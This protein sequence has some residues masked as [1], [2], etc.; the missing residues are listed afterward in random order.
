MQLNEQIEK[1]KNKDF[2]KLEKGKTSNLLFNFIKDEIIIRSYQNNFKKSYFD[3]NISN[4]RAIIGLAFMT[5]NGSI[6]FYIKPLDR[7]TYRFYF[8][9]YTECMKNSEIM[10]Y[11]LKYGLNIPLNVEDDTDI[12]NYEL[13]I[14]EIENNKLVLTD[15][16]T[17]KKTEILEDIKH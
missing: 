8:K 17:N 5:I 13:D 1:L 12:R 15:L 7:K 6:D 9:V 14:F 11:N 4:T 10:G 3:L 2:E 16:K